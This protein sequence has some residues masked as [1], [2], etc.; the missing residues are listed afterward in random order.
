MK[1]QN[2]PV[3]L[4]Q[5]IFFNKLFL[6]FGMLVVLLYSVV[7][8]ALPLVSQYLIDVVLGTSLVSQVYTG[9]II[10]FVVCIT[11]PILFLSK[12]EYLL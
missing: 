11:Q 8:V 7:L 4:S 1:K 5:F 6:V 12:R 9:I 3:K 10:F 2:N